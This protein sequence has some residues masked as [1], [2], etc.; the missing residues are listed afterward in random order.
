MSVTQEAPPVVLPIEDATTVE[1]SYNKL[2]NLG[3]FAHPE[4][5]PHL[6]AAFPEVHAARPEWPARSAYVERKMWEVAMA[7]RTFADFGVLN[8]RTDVLGVGA[9]RERTVFELTNHVGRL[10]ATD[11]YA[12]TH[13]GSWVADA[14]SSMLV[15]PAA[16]APVPF[17][18]RRLVVQHMNALDLQYEDDSFD[19]IFSSSSIEHFGTL[20]DVHLAAR[21]MHRVLKPGGILSLSTEFRLAGPA[22]GIPGALLM[23]PAELEV[24][25][26]HDLGWSL[27]SQPDFALSEH[28]AQGAWSY[29]EINRLVRAGQPAPQHIVLWT[30]EHAWT[31]VHLAIVKDALTTSR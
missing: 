29:D 31:S 14:T 5:V 23:T 24:V 16:S 12:T 25:L 28:T 9:G 17:N 26:M 15:D 2:C 22:P 7:M 8:G 21:E 10:F 13:G 6:V 30:G 1:L 3:D 18:P 20:E 19:A 27:V 4:L 11:L